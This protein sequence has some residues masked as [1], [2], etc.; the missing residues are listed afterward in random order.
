MKKGIE[1]K[2]TEA[3][4]ATLK[5]DIESSKKQVTSFQQAVASCIE[6]IGFL[7]TIREKMARTASQASAQARETKEELKVK[8]LLI[9]DLTKKLQ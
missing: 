9:L 2:S 6:E 5:E 8:E 1:H 3:K 7:S 4:I